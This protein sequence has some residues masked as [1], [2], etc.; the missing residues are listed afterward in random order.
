[1][2]NMVLSAFMEKWE[3][4]LCLCC[5]YIFSQSL[6]VVVSA[7]IANSAA[8]VAIAVAATVVVVAALLLLLNYRIR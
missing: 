6:T 2:D 3:R 4:N 7:L 1:M 5:L 8:A